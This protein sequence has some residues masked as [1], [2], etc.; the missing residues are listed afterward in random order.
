MAEIEGQDPQSRHNNALSIARIALFTAAAVA[1]GYLLSAVPN[2]ELLTAIVALS[3]LLLGPLKGLLVGFFAELIFGGLNPIGAPF[4]PVWIAQMLGMSLTGLVFG[5]LGK[6]F[7]FRSSVKQIALLSFSGAFMTTLFD[8]L[9]NIAFPIS[10]G[11]GVEQWWAYLIAGIPFA[12]LHILFNTMIF[13]IL[14]PVA[15]KRLKRVIGP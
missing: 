11:A 9:T 7:P 8:I 13:A 15:Y 14:V 12:G 4:P 1:F 2:V 3:G 6:F 10:I 5:F